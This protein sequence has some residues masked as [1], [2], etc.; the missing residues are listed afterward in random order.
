MRADMGLGGLERVAGP[1]FRRGEPGY[2]QAREDAVW[3]ARKP[4]RY[5]DLI[6]IAVTQDDAAA[7]V[8]HARAEGLQVA[9]RS[10]GHSWCGGH[11][12]DGGLLL[13]L[14]RLREITVDPAAHRVTVQAG[15]VGADVHEALVPHGL[16]FPVGHGPDVGLAGFLLGGGYGWNSRQLGPAC[17]SIEA[18]DAVTADGEIVHSTPRSNS[19]ILWAARGGGHGQFAAITRFHLR[20]YPAPGAIMRSTY[21]YPLK[22]AGDLVRLMMAVGPELSRSV[23]FVAM[24]T[25]PPAG[26]F[27]GA[28][29]TMSG[30]AFT[31]TLEEAESLL[32]P[33]DRAAFADAAWAQTYDPTDLAAMA[34]EVQRETPRGLRYVADN[35]WTRATPDEIAPAFQAITDSMPN[36]AS[37]VFWYFW[38]E[39][40][41][42]GQ[43]AWSV[44]A[45]WYLGVYGIGD[46]PATD[47]QHAAWVTKSIASVEP[48]SAGT[49]FA[50]AD[51]GQRFDRP[52]SDASLARMEELR[53]T[54]DPTG[55]FYGYR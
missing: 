40:H 6:V 36:A 4:A 53:A 35:I 31:D 17:L 20:L 41:D 9:L 2:E 7:A 8:R 37:Q 28:A 23:E 33:L 21:V 38:G 54:Y 46:D 32:E 11:L 22:A 27:D 30:T 50:D 16:F 1:V 12:H 44:Q 24:A 14:S 18:V 45:P 10:G 49:Q 47:E 15:V 42:P 51:L 5:P 52:L 34:A 26:G 43:A 39:E 55:L 13:D 25:L 29:V 3:N 48:L 19:D